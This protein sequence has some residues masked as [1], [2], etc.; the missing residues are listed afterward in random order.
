MEFLPSPKS[1]LYIINRKVDLQLDNKAKPY[2]INIIQEDETIKTAIL[3]FNRK[4]DA[5]FFANTLEYH[6]KVFDVYPGNTFDYKRPLEILI[7]E[8]VNIR[9]LLKHPDDLIITKISERDIFINSSKNMTNLMIVDSLEGFKYTFK[10]I[11]F[12]MP[13]ETQVTYLDNKLELD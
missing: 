7:P 6:R 9:V 1:Y 11:N 10:I 3:S 8:D 5:I 4:K 13:I 12:E 2:I